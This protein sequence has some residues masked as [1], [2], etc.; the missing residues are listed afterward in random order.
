MILIV[1]IWI[2]LLVAFI[3]TVA[4]YRKYLRRYSVE[5]T[6]LQ[7]LKSYWNRFWRL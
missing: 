6:Y 3:W 2:I 4:D 5:M 7:F 1:A